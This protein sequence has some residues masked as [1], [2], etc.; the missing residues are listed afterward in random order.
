M[1]SAMKAACALTCLLL[2]AGCSGGDG[3]S[4]SEA[5]QAIQ[6]AYQN[7]DFENIEQ[8]QDQFWFLGR[9]HDVKCSDVKVQ[10]CKQTVPSVD[11]CNVSL[12]ASFSWNGEAKSETL[13]RMMTFS[14][15]SDGNYKLEKISKL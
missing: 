14:V 9:V 1:N 15:D 13:T 5:A 4:D 3:P 6:S 2:V 8:Q 11:A 12:Q 10:G 7:G